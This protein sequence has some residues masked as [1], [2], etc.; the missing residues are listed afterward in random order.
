[1]DSLHTESMVVLEHART[2][3]RWPHYLPRAVEL[4]L[5][6]QLALRLYNDGETLGGLNLYSTESD[7]VD[8]EARH[9]AELFASHAAIALGRARHEHQLN[10][11]IAS[12]KVVG[13]AIGIVMERYEIAEDRAFHF[14]V[15][16]SSTS[17]TKLRDVAQEMVD[18]TNARFAAKDDHP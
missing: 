12:R 2:D 16:A 13:Q 11:A 8:E 5:R 4:G 3:E 18:S 7:T 15:R 1:V 6:A 17:N 14:L 10:E 9:V